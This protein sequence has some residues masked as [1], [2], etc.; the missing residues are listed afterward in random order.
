MKLIDFFCNNKACKNYLKKIEGF[1]NENLHCQHCLK[2]MER[3]TL[4]NH[5]VSGIRSFRH[6]DELNEL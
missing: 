5:A 3:S 4:M 6:A 2:K 1:D